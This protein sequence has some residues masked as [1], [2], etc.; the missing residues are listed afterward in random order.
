MRYKATSAGGATTVET[1][2]EKWKAAGPSTDAAITNSGNDTIE[3]IT[4]DPGKSVKLTGTDHSTDALGVIEARIE[5]AEEMAKAHF[6]DSVA[7]CV[8]NGTIARLSID[9]ITGKSATAEKDDPAAV[10]AAVAAC[11]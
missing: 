6:P 10:S 5:I 7:E 3:L 2:L 8:S 1:L 4:C 11:H 9:D